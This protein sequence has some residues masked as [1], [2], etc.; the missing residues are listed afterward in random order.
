MLIYRK[1]LR[2]SCTDVV[3][4]AA[5]TLMGNDVETLV[6]R[7]NCLFIECWANGI[8]VIFAIYLLAQQLGAV[9]VVPVVT[10]ISK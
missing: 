5:V 6:E 8:T 7:V 3:D 1:V 2:L 4:S 9:C 10:A